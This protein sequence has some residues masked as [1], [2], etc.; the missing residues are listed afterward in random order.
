MHYDHYGG[1]IDIISARRRYLPTDRK[2]L[3]LLCPKEDLKSWLLFYDNTVEQIHDE[4]SFIDNKNLVSVA[5][6]NFAMQFQEAYHFS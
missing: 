1:L 2:P 5:H 6:N 3:Y 4:L